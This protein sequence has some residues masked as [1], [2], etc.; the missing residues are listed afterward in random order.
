MMVAVKQGYLAVVERLIDSGCDPNL[1]DAKGN[2]ALHYAFSYNH[3]NTWQMLIN[4]NADE[5]I[6]NNDGLTAW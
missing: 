2:T 6:V 5:L 4:H 3:K 1:Q